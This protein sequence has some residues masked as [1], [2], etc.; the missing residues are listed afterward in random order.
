VFVV[1]RVWETKPGEARKAASL[2]TAMGKEYESVEKR[3]PSRVY[4]NTSTVPGET[5]DTNNSGRKQPLAMQGVMSLKSMFSTLKIH[6]QLM[7]NF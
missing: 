4:F 5:C 3:S 1:R 2:V 7:G 6:P